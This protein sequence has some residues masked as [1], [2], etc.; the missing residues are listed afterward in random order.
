MQNTMFIQRFA[1]YIDGTGQQPNISTNEIAEI[2]IPVPS[3]DEQYHIS[4]YLDRMVRN[5]DIIINYRKKIIDR[6]I[7]YKK[8]IIYEVVTGKREV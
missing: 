8:S 6:L 4:A 2:P 3:V 1:L 5:T 7:D